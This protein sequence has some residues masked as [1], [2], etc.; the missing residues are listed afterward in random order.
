[1]RETS[2]SAATASRPVQGDVCDPGQALLDA[3]KAI[4]DPRVPFPEMTLGDAL[5]PCT[6]PEDHH[7]SPPTAGDGDGSAALAWPGMTAGVTAVVSGGAYAVDTDALSGFATALANAAGYLDDARTH[8]LDAETEARAAV[9]RPTPDWGYASQDYE[10][11]LTLSNGPCP[12]SSGDSSS[13]DPQYQGEDLWAKLD[14][15]LSHTCLQLPEAPKSYCT[16]PLGSLGLPGFEALRTNA[17]D[18]IAALT[19]G[20]GS[21]QSVADSLRALATDVTGCVSVYNGAESGATSAGGIGAFGAMTWGALGML[22][23]ASS[24]AGLLALLGATAAATNPDLTRYADGDLADVL[25]DLTAVMSDADLADWVKTDLL[26]I[27]ILVDYARRAGTSRETAAIETYLAGVAQRLDPEI[28]KK[29]P[30]ELTAGGGR[31]VPTTSLT[32]MERVVYYMSVLSADVAARRFGDPADLTLAVHGGSSLTIPPSGRDPMAWGTSVPALRKA[33]GTAADG[34]KVDGPLGTASDVIRYSDSLKAQDEDPSSGVISIVRTTHADGTNSWMV[35]VPG[36]TD[37]GLGGTN[38][39]DLLTNLQAVAGAPND[40]ES[41][42]VAAM[43][44]AGIGPDDPVG[45]YGHSQGAIVASNVAADPTVNEHYNVTTLLT[46]GGPTA[47]ADLPDNVNA[48][49]LENGADA[50][51]GLDGAPTPRTPTRTVV[52]VDT[53]GSDLKGYPHGSLVYADAVEGMSGDPAIDA[54]T[55]QLG[56]LTGTGEE[57]ATT[58]A[59]V[60]DI[61]RNTTG[62]PSRSGSSSRF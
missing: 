57:G 25:D 47:G 6:E 17:L 19:T 27:A 14:R 18:A 45:I 26:R 36:T 12:A 61:T 53:T 38:P 13:G 23:M 32:P 16:S 2:M 29:L 37:W 24:P 9:A 62:A 43:R 3:D 59:F 21:L 44:R 1:M 48:L 31:V 15:P 50:V 42:V 5:T 7:V 58:S 34:E 8:A 52:T 4:Q 46:A 35:V 51:P 54:W 30:E 10:P 22:V 28:S 55:R 39:Q 40:M 20:S 49:H 56:S 11:V 41:S 33:D 60:F